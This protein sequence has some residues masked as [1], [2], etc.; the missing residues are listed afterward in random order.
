MCAHNVVVHR[1]LRERG[2]VAAKV[3]ATVLT[4]GGARAGGRSWA[5]LGLERARLGTG[6][7]WGLATAPVLLLSVGAAASW[8]R[9]RPAFDDDRVRDLDTGQAAWQLAVRIPL[10]TAVHEEVLFRG[11]LPA[12]LAQA[13]GARRARLGAALL[14][15]LWHVLPTWDLAR[16]NALASSDAPAGDAPA[17]WRR[18]ASAAGAVV[19]T[20]VAGLG[21]GW[22]RDRSGSIAAPIVTH[23]VLND[24]AFVTGLLA[25]RRL[26]RRGPTPTPTAHV[27]A[28]RPRTVVDDQA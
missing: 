5:D 9:T 14:F 11:V 19:I 21:F 6:I 28:A 25:Q 23:L 13:V 8:P 20:T 17:R 2:E 4:V 10:A 26:A 7:G 15:G 27:G 16:G 3:A 18:T 12:V 22:L 1:V 24:A